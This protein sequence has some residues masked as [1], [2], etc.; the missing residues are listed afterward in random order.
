MYFIKSFPFITRGRNRPAM[1]ALCRTK[2]T[3]LVGR[4][5]PWPAAMAKD[6][7]AAEAGGWEEETDQH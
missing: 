4:V 5:S 7:D 3:P 6:D 1:L 2:S